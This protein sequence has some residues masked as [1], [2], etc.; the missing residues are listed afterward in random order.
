M[1]SQSSTPAKCR[2]QQP[3]PRTATG[4][5]LRAAGAAPEAQG[6]HRHQEAPPLR[7]ALLALG[8]A[9]WSVMSASFTGL[10][11]PRGTVSRAGKAGPCHGGR[12]ARADAPPTTRGLR[13]HWAG[14]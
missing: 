7:L 12:Q 1:A 11:S 2:P 4:T 3:P 13:L 14:P 9:G 6:G 8:S 5:F 10:L